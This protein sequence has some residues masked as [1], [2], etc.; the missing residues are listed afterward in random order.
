MAATINTSHAVLLKGAAAGEE[1]TVSSSTSSSC[2]DVTAASKGRF[3]SDDFQQFDGR[4]AVAMDVGQTAVGRLGPFQA[5]P[6]HHGRSGKHAQ[7]GR[8]FDAAEDIVPDKYTAQRR[9]GCQNLLAH[10]L[11][12]KTKIHARDA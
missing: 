1:L 5:E 4:L 12:T 7:E 3:G 6:F 11:A 10:G 8:R 9:A 2:A